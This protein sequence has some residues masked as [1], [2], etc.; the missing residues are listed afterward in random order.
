MVEERLGS[1]V[2]VCFVEGVRRRG[3]V[4]FVW[5]FEGKRVN[6]WGGPGGFVAFLEKFTKLC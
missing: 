2:R 6:R 1:G 3:S 5:N 4:G